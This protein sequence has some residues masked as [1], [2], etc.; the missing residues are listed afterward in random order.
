MQEKDLNR[1]FPKEAI[2]MAKKHMK[3]NHSS[4]GKCKSKPQWDTAS[5]LPEGL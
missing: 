2:Q 1:H 4:L 5:Y 3:S